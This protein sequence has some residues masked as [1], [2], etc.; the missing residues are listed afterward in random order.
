M[1]L[2]DERCNSFTLSPTHQS[3]SSSQKHAVV[4]TRIKF[5]RG[6]K[7]GQFTPV[8]TAGTDF[9][10]LR[11]CG[12]Q[13][14]RYP[15]HS[16]CDMSGVCSQEGKGGF[17]KGRMEESKWVFVCLFVNVQVRMG[18]GLLPA[19]VTIGIRLR[20]AA[21]CVLFCVCL[22]CFCFFA[23]GNCTNSWVSETLSPVWGLGFQ[24]GEFFSLVSNCGFI[25]HFLMETRTFKTC[26]WP[27]RF[28][29][30]M[31]LQIL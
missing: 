24:K 7:E 3:C 15:E 21:F 1:V 5:T 8:S 12:S 9:K 26:S 27:L 4:S 28:P 22:F 18:L 10:S 11:G 17:N 25:V 16:V 20:S 13:V 23:S 30:E 6:S 2:T 19:F 29:S 14:P 31:L